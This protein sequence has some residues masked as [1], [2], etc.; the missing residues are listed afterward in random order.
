MTQGFEFEEDTPPPVQKRQSV[1]SKSSEDKKKGPERQDFVYE[2]RAGQ[3]YK[4]WIL[5]ILMTVITLGIYYFWGKTR[6]RRY[7][8][9][10]FSLA[11]DHFEYHGTGGELFKGFLKAVPIMILLFVVPGLVLGEDSPLVL[12]AIPPIYYIFSIA[13][14]SATRYRFSRTTWRGIRAMLGG[15]TLKYANLSF[16][17]MLLN[18][19]TL[20]FAIPHSDIAKHKYIIEN[21]YFG[22][23][24]AEYKGS[25]SVI[26]GAYIKSLLLIPVFMIIFGIIIGGPLTILLFAIEGGG[27]HIMPL[28]LV[29]GYFA[30]I[31][32]MMIAFPIARAFYKAALMQEKMRGIHVAGLRFRC[33]VTGWGLVR[34]RFVNGLIIIFTL[35]L[36]LPFV[37]QRN[38]RF[39][40]R[41]NFIIGDLETSEIKQAQDQNIRSGEGIED[42]MGVDVG[43]F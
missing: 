42:F 37:I 1:T 21:T 9:G 13:L 38:M 25:G 29:G 26:F 23:L 18:I 34:H 15:D 39:F 17:R 7:Q 10:S 12:L 35:G 14:F 30:L 24:K 3:I 22:S 28:I 43:V 8:L 20:G 5:N 16:R 32:I 33:N 6:L 40:S 11:G 41:H 4:I 19:V 31:I 2:G 27:L 36:G